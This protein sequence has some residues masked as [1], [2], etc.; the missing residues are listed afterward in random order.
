MKRLSIGCLTIALALLAL[1]VFSLRSDATPSL[2]AD[3]ALAPPVHAERG[4]GNSLDQGGETCSNA[5]Q[6]ISLPYC[7]EGTTWWY[8]DNY[9]PPCATVFGGRQRACRR[10]TL[11]SE[12]RPKRCLPVGPL[13]G[14]AATE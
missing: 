14:N 9:T 7:D 5:T 1:W 12:R 13:P 6:I 4:H 8:A 3:A 11:H 2:S 10:G